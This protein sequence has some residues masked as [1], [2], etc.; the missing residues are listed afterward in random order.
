MAGDSIGSHVI[1]T[2]N[3]GL[4][5]KEVRIPLRDGELPAYQAH[6]EDDASFPVVVV[7]HEIFGVHEHIKDVCRRFAKLGYM[8]IAP[9]LFARSGAILK[10]ADISEIMSK[11]INR[12]SDDQVISD[13]DALVEWLKKN[14]KA[15]IT[16]LGITGFCW[17]GRITWLYC[18]HNPLV[19]AGVAWYGRLEGTTTE[20]QPKHPIEIAQQLKAPVLGL[21]GGVD[22]SIPLESVKRMQAALSAAHNACEIVV[23]DNAPHAF[24]ADYRAGYRKEE[25][26]NGWQRLL[27]WFR[28]HGIRPDIA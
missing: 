4:I 8:A 16:K 10:N 17:G 1:T 9:E 28:D 22:Q 19:K 25:A 3:D 27:L 18:A 23:Y 24:F 6:P 11:V 5:V 15:E 26:D 21:Y 12:V 13:L 7:V 2:D 14:D 20:L